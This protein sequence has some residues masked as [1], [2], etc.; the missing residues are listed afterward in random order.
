VE[1]HKVRKTA[2]HCPDRVMQRVC[3]TENQ[4][5]NFYTGRAIPGLGRTQHKAWTDPYHLLS[6]N[7]KRCVDSNP[8]LSK[9]SKTRKALQKRLKEHVKDGS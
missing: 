8:K 7:G 5:H 4:V 1:C 2:S 6:K 9:R 3:H